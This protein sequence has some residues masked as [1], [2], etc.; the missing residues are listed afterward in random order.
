MPE[1]GVA[2]QRLAELVVERSDLSLSKRRVETV[3]EPTDRLPRIAEHPR[4]RCRRVRAARCRGGPAC[5]VHA[6]AEGLAGSPTL[7][8]LRDVVGEA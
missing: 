5:R 7:E 8:Q 2:E 6:T 1:L 3:E 4:G